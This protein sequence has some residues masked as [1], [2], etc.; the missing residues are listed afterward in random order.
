MSI[1]RCIIKDGKEQWI[2]VAG[3]SS[4]INTG[5]AINVSIRDNDNLFESQN[6]EGALTEISYE[7][8]N[9]DNVLTNHINNS[10]IH[11][12]GGGGGSMP[13]ITSD[14]TINAGTIQHNNTQITHGNIHKLRLFARNPMIVPLKK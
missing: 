2:E 7:I 1:K 9:V 5:E 8:Q 3:G 6:V 4:S 10:A 11:G 13:T 12:G 14:F